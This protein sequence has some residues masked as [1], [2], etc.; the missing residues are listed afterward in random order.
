VADVREPDSIIRN[1]EIRQV[2]DFDKPIAVL[3]VA[4]MHFISPAEDPASLIAAYLDAVAPGSTLTLTHL[5]VSLDDEPRRDE[6]LKAWDHAVSRL[7]SR[8]AEEVTGFFTGLDVV[9]PGVVQLQR[10]RPDADTDTSVEIQVHGGV[11]LKR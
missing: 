2:L 3:M 9:E 6:A 11:G 10:W 8:T 5:T 4:L 1:S 7:Y